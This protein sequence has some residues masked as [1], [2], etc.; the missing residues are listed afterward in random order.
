M[1]YNDLGLARP[2]GGPLPAG[3]ASLLGP[4]PPLAAGSS[5]TGS[6]LGS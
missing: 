4:A 2:S 5:P 6:P 1:L 3:L